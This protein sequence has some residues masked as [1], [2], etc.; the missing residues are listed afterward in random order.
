MQI[1]E[2]FSFPLFQCSPVVVTVET[3]SMVLT[4]HF[5]IYEYFIFIQL[6]FQYSS[7]SGPPPDPVQSS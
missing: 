2:V 5:L 7:L 4:I 3:C 1:A 6:Y